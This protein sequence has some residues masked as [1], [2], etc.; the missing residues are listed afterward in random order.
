MKKVDLNLC[1]LLKC[2][3]KYEQI[4]LLVRKADIVAAKRPAVVIRIELI[5]ERKRAPDH[6]V[7]K[8]TWITA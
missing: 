6:G 2:A 7:I 5:A 4:D 1:G 8:S 3:E